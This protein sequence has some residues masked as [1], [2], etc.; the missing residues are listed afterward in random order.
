MLLVNTVI[1]GRLHRQ[2]FIN[3][4][5]HKLKIYRTK[6]RMIML[7]VENIGSILVFSTGK[8]RAM[9]RCISTNWIYSLNIPIY[10]CIFQTSTYTHD[11]TTPIIL[12]NIDIP[13]H[14]K[15]F[16]EPELFNCMTIY[17]PNGPTINLFGSG[18]I[19]F[20]GVRNIHR[21]YAALRDIE[22]IIHRSL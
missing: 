13:S 20:L 11:L 5:S 2:Q 3:K 21:A 18:K 7:K 17:Y 19:V 14:W 1:R 12:R 9:G 15:H 8:F 4:Y 6:P 22:E 10:E 16:W